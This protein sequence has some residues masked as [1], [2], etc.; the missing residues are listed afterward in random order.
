MR[1]VS[2]EIAP[3]V[4]LL[5]VLLVTGGLW[6][7]QVAPAAAAGESDF[8]GLTPCRLVDTRGNGF[9]G[10]FGPPALDTGVPRD[11]PI[12][13]QCGIPAKALAVSLNVTATNT[14][15]PGFLLLYPQGGVQP[16]V[17]TLNYVGGETV[18][19]AAIV[20]LG[21][22]GLTIV[23]GVSGTELILDVNGYFTDSFVHVV[24]GALLVGLGAPAVDTTGV[25]TGVLTNSTG[26][27]NSALG[28]N[29]LANN[30]EAHSNT[31][32]GAGALLLN[33]VGSQNTAVGRDALAANQSGER[34][35]AVGDLALSQN[36]SGSV[37]I[38]LGSRAG[39]V[40]DGFGNIA[41]GHLG[42]AGENLTIRL[43]TQSQ[44]GGIGH[45][46]TFIAGIHDVSPA[47]MDI[48][49]VFIDRDGQLGAPELAASSRR[50]KTDI[51]DIGERSRGL[52]RL[53]PVSFHFRTR[54]DGPLQ[55]GL[56][57]E[58]VTEI[59]PELVTR[60]AEGMP[61]TVR[62]DLLPA[63]LLN[64]LQRQERALVE[65]DRQ[66]TELLMA[67]TELTA[68]LARLEARSPAAAERR[69]DE[70]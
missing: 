9:G 27:G 22:G 11:F 62:Y 48:R 17:S 40:T 33:T 3:V 19:N 35:T 26:S 36:I 41:I 42:V 39:E 16:L 57:A 59:Y 69:G 63:L 37:N 10:A 12:Q 55:Y 28:S 1:H 34:N 45:A 6:W 70:R 58:E 50:M 23:A 32:I 51:D 60:D 8:V 29:A 56:I 15:G 68:R 20:P 25:G 14:Q 66:L 18:A 30:L 43:G 44:F 31:A 52:Q 47:G 13:G 7:M 53:R 67:L 4:R 54:P 24:N 65:K 38:A 49:Q 64:E 2:Q 5:S 21:P 46:R 61:A